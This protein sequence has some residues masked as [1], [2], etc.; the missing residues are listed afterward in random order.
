MALALLFVSCKKKDA[1]TSQSFTANIENNSSR[2]YLEGL[3]VKWTEDD[4]IMVANNA[5]TQITFQLTEGATTQR[6]VFYTGDPKKEGFFT[7]PFKAVYPAKNPQTNVAN[8]ISNTTATVYL[9]NEQYITPA[10]TVTHGGSGDLDTET[11]VSFGNGYNPMVAYSDNQTLQFKNLLGG[12]CFPLKGNGGTFHITKI[13]LTANNT[14]DKLWGTATVDCSSNDPIISI[15]NTAANKH[16]LILNCDIDLPA[17]DV[18]K[19]LFM[20]PP[21]TLTTG[22]DIEVFDNTTSIY[23]ASK[24]WESSNSVIK[25][26]QLRSTNTELEVGT[27]PAVTTTAVSLLRSVS[28]TFSGNVTSTGG[29]TVVERGFCIST[30]PTPTINDTKIIVGNGS[31]SYSINYTSLNPVTTYYVRAYATNGAGTSYGA[32]ISFTTPVDGFTANSLGSKVYLAPGNLQWLGAATAPAS[33]HC[34]FALHQYDIIS[35][36]TGPNNTTQNSEERYAN[37]DLFGWG[38]S[39]QNSTAPFPWTISKSDSDYPHGSDIAGTNLDWGVYHYVE[40]NSNGNSQERGWRTPT[41][42]ELQYIL[43]TRSAST[44][45]GT[46][47]ARYAKAIVNNHSGLIIFPDHYTHPSGITQPTQINIQGAAYSSNNYTDAQW[48]SMQ[49]QGAVFLPC[50]DYRDGTALG[51]QNSYGVYWTSTYA[52]ASE[53]GHKAYRLEFTGNSVGITNGGQTHYGLCVR[54]VMDEGT[55]IIRNNIQHQ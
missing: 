6:G 54:L 21:G 19:F 16:Q 35:T 33:P 8:S 55:W 24:T 14:N 4:L 9:P 5:G 28:A 12:L 3:N 39:G 11:T 40:N 25:R 49:T 43:F 37:R 10:Q 7:G 52:N 44:I 31:G 42:Q 41:S 13:V 1:E 26:N 50:A 17:A 36:S 22:M 2:T 18:H 20:L 15:T 46:S 34:R 48:T 27:A 47:N 45:N 51:I 38:T 53:G 32:Q 30:S 29:S 23:H